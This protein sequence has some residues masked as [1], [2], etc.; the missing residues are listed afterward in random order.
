METSESVKRAA[1]ILHLRILNGSIL[2]WDYKNLEIFIDQAVFN[3]NKEE[4]R[5]AKEHCSCGA[6]ISDKTEICSSCDKN[7]RAIRAETKASQLRIAVKSAINCFENIGA[8]GALRYEEDWQKCKYVL[9]E[10]RKVE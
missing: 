4:E 2:T 7:I 9:E 3:A 1:E 10:L 5:K 6:E 8:Y